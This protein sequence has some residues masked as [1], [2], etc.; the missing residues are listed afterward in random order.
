MKILT[1]KELSGIINIKV[2]TLYQWAEFGQIPCIK[3][4]GALRFDLDDIMEWI[5]SC[6][7]ETHSGYNPFTQA[8]GPRKGGGN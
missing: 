5:K 6:K 7:R 2:K 1:V 3:M 4:Q 8:R